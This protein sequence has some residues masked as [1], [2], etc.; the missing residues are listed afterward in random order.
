M[1]FTGWLGGVRLVGLSLRTGSSTDNECGA[2]GAEKDFRIHD[3]RF[4][5]GHLQRLRFFSRPTK[6]AERPARVVAQA[7]QR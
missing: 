2:E 6:G 5:P 4:N 3:N 7:G 1:G